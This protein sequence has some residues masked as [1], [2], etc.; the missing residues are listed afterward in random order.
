MAA[1]ARV[2]QIVGDRW[3]KSRDAIERRR[4]IASP[5]LYAGDRAQKAVGADGGYLGANR[6]KRT[7]RSIGESINGPL[8]ELG[9][10]DQQL[11]ALVNELQIRL[12]RVAYRRGGILFQGDQATNSINDP[13]DEANAGADRLYQEFDNQFTYTGNRDTPGQLFIHAEATATEPEVWLEIPTGTTPY[14][15]PDPPPIDAV[16][17][18]NNPPTLPAG[19]GGGNPQNGFLW[20]DTVGLHLWDYRADT[21]EWANQS[22]AVNHVDSPSDMDV[23][24][25]FVDGDRITI[26]NGLNGRYCEY[27]FREITT[28]PIPS[29]GEEHWV[30]LTCC[31]GICP[32]NPPE[33]GCPDGQTAEAG[34]SGWVICSTP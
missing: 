9:G 18:I 32:P 22:G 23:L 21:N 20:Y 34:N 13:N 33:E 2:A 31:D 26:L 3:R 29:N 4:D 11:V 12:E 14:Y 5:E 25:H 24:R 30:L 28:E 16:D 19:A 8:G 7:S 15:S 10:I 1:I 6:P 17:P 27:E